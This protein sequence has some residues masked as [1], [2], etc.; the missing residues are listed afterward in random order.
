MS[1][2]IGFAGAG[3]VAWHLAPAL[4]NMG[5]K[6]THV[7]NRSSKSGTLLVK[8]LY[9]GEFIS[10]PN[11]TALNLDILF[12]CVPDDAIESLAD[13][14]KVDNNTIVVHTSGPQSLD[15]LSYRFKRAGVFYPL[16]TFSKNK[17]V[18]FQDI[19]L[20]IEG[21]DSSTENL[22][23]G[24]AKKLSSQTKRVGSTERKYVHLSAVFACNFSNHM[25][26]IAEGILKEKGQNL[27]ILYP[28]ISETI[29]KALEVGPA[30]AQTG[31]ARRQ[32]LRTLDKHL[33][34]LNKDEEVAEIYRLIS[35]HILDTYNH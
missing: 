18:D 28:L 26:Y 16:Q 10:E 34:M 35:Q 1:L 17:K 13:E 32:D 19:P 24:I 8:R 6:I 21:S 3:N 14:I 20:L 2:N 9:Q 12:L 7:Y 30:G 23:L 27:Q 29:N 22:L 11:F 33:D 5:I 15:I 25:L 31:P 4:E